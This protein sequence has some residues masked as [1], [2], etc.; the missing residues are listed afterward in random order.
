M[1]AHTAD[2][3]WRGLEKLWARSTVLLD[4]CAPAPLAQEREEELAVDKG[5]FAAW[6]EAWRAGAPVVLPDLAVAP[7]VRVPCGGRGV[8]RCLTLKQI[9]FLQRF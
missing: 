4:K 3:E 9:P 5:N 8:R 7:P 2:G 6:R 1:T